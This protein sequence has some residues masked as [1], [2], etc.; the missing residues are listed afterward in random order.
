[1][2]NTPGQLVYHLQGQQVAEMLVDADDAKTAAIADAAAAAPSAELN[3]GV[4]AAGKAT[5]S[6]IR[7]RFRAHPKLQNCSPM[8]CPIILS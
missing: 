2:M 6:A 7:I 1:M 3:G 4:Q 8:T 5:H